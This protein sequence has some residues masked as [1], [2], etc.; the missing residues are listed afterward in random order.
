DGR[1]RIY[2]LVNASFRPGIAQIPPDAINIRSTPDGTCIVAFVKEEIKE[3]IEIMPSSQLDDKN[4]VTNSEMQV[5]KQLVRGYV[6]F[7]E[8]FSR[9]ASKIIDICFV[10]SPE[11]FQFSMFENRQMHLTTI[12]QE[13]GTFNSAI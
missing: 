10:K 12:D 1:A 2:N 7:C 11:I 5:P 3:E 9:H 4:L 13:K 6:Y 8:N